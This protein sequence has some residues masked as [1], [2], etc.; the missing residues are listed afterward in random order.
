MSQL[1]EYFRNNKGNFIN[2]TRRHVYLATGFDDG[3]LYN[4]SKL[5]EE[6]LD[7]PE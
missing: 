1:V 5:T 2:K 4:I 3:D 7:S 6:G